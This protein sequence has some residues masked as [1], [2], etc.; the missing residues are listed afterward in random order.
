MLKRS[1]G[2]GDGG[3]ELGMGGLSKLVGEMRQPNLEPF[4][5]RGAAIAA[6]KEVKTDIVVCASVSNT[7]GIGVSMATLA[8][9]KE[10]DSKLVET[11]EDYFRAVNLLHAR[12]MSIDGVN[13]ENALTVDGRA[14]GDMRTPMRD[15]EET[16]AGTHANMA[17]NMLAQ[18]DIV[19]N[20]QV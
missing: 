4:V 14:M 16:A 15:L 8:A 10:P 6:N 12:G 7:G 11:A 13:K 2:I 3:N 9:S 17:W 20:T 5:G 18:F 19:Q 1:M